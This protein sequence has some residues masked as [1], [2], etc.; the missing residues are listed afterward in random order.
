[1]EEER[2]RKGKPTVLSHV[3]PQALQSV[4][5]PSGPR[6]ILG[7]ASLRLSQLPH[8]QCK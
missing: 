5:G 8:L 3:K 1:M 7:V 6:R 4:P 2:A